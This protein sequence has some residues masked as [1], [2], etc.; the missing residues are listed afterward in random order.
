MKTTQDKLDTAIVQYKRSIQLLMILP[1]GVLFTFFF[2]SIV[3][4]IITMAIIFVVM[5]VW[6]DLIHTMEEAHRNDILNLIYT[7]DCQETIA[8]LSY[9][10]HL[11]DQHSLAGSRE[12]GAHSI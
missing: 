12:F 2:P 4:T 7:S 6:C 3:L 11:H 9:E 5:F 1:H 10:L 8:I